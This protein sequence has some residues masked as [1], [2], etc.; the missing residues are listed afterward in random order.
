VTRSVQKYRES[1]V[2][3]EAAAVVL[4]ELSQM[5][6]DIP[7]MRGL[8]INPLLA[9]EIGVLAVDARVAMATWN[10]YSATGD[11]PTFQFGPIRRNGDVTS[12]AG[13][14][15]R[16]RANHPSEDE[17]PIHELLRCMNSQDLRLRFFGA[18]KEFSP[19]FIARL[20]QLDY[21][22]AMAIA[23]FEEITK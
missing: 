22:R 21:A 7:E 17:P 6:A 3:E 10:G 14:G 23:A 15:G 13:R 12:R 9:D 11:L 4:V 18:K 8:D 16:I 2:K 1:A 20:T 19:E 5:A